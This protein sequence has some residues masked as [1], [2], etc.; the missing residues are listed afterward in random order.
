MS[1]D[2]ARLARLIADLDSDQ[3]ETRRR[4]SQAL[5]H[6]NESAI[7]A[8]RKALAARPS[9]EVRRR[10][11]E[12]LERLEGPLPAERL[13]EVRAIEVLEHQAT[14]VAIALL[15]SLAQGAPGARLTEE[16]RASLERLKG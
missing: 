9:A 7:P 13:R 14:Q 1:L 5:E 3:F 15:R 4:A 10:L 12:I 6:L 11:E 2:V 8:L 16:A